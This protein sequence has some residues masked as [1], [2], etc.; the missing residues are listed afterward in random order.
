ME[1]NEPTKFTELPPDW[2]LVATHVVPELQ[3]CGFDFTRATLFYIYKHKKCSP[4]QVIYSVKNFIDQCKTNPTSFNRFKNP[5]A[6]LIASLKKGDL[7]E[8]QSS[9]PDKSALS[10]DR[11][12]CTFVADGVACTLPG[13]YAELHGSLWTC[14]FHRADYHSFEEKR[15][16]LSSI[17]MFAPTYTPPVNIAGDP[18][19]P[20]QLPEIPVALIY[21]AAGFDAKKRTRSPS[22]ESVPTLGAACS[23]LSTEQRK[24]KISAWKQ[25]RMDKNLQAIKDDPAEFVINMNISTPL[26]Q[27]LLERLLE[28]DSA[29]NTH[30]NLKTLQ[31]ILEEFP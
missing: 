26:K 2:E 17:L 14:L 23:T 15:V 22:G 30:D 18:V 21:R 8:P 19:P 11:H 27:L 9:K 16:L 24:K 12:R 13:D 29:K 6:V 7:W 3:A 25:A 4:E 28:P 10:P 31:A 5:I 1:I 20:D